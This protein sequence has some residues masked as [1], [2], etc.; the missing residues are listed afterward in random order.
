[1][2]QG[3]KALLVTTESGKLIPIL[4]KPLWQDATIMYSPTTAM[5]G[6]ELAAIVAAQAP[7]QDF[8]RTATNN[9]LLLY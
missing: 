6:N 5:G 8:L 2:Q 3:R 4:Q 9:V 7:Q 1:M